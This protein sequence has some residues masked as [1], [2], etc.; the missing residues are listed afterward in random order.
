MLAFCS[1]RFWCYCSFFY[2]FKRNILDWDAAVCRPFK[3]PLEEVAAMNLA[4]PLAYADQTFFY[5][6]LELSMRAFQ[7][8]TALPPPSD[9]ALCHT[10]VQVHHLLHTCHRSHLQRFTDQHAPG[11]QQPLGRRS[12]SCRPRLAHWPSRPHT[13]MRVLTKHAS[14]WTT[15]SS[16]PYTRT[17]GS[18]FKTTSNNKWH[19]CLVEASWLQWDHVGQAVWR[20]ESKA[21]DG[22][23]LIL[24]RAWEEGQITERITLPLRHWGLGLSP[25]KP[26]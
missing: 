21:V 18:C 1:C 8:F 15:C 17:A 9:S 22:V 11:P 12:T 19:T 2:E 23:F 14:S 3:G 24:G 20:A 7:S 5:R 10:C 6:S 16:C 4:R 13:L 26:H 25:H